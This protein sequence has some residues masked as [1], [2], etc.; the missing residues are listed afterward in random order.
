MKKWPIKR[1]YR[2]SVAF[3]WGARF[4]ILSL[5]VSAIFYLDP[6]ENFGD[7]IEISPAT[8]LLA[9]NNENFSPMFYVKNNT[10]K[11]VNQI[12]LKLILS[13]SDISLR[14]EDII[15]KLISNDTRMSLDVP[16]SDSET[17]INLSDYMTYVGAIDSSGKQAFFIF[18]NQ[19]APKEMLQI[20]ISNSYP[21]KL[22]GEH[23]FK[24]SFLN[25]SDEPVGVFTDKDESLEITLPAIGEEI[26]VFRSG[27][28][29]RAN[30]T[31]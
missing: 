15:V 26:T 9:K 3:R 5:I 8:I 27:I 4:F 1:L 21:R 11:A 6:I 31:P 28:I 10:N 14:N 7:K 23:F 16:V 22:Q 30:V 29:I 17:K 18:R 20:Q 2:D 24:A 12:W 25:S 13:S 19:L